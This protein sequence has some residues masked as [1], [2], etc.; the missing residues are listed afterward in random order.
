MVSGV[1]S[2]VALAVGSCMTTANIAPIN[3]KPIVRFRYGDPM[4][5]AAR[6]NELVDRINELERK[7]SRPS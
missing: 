4:P 1:L 6:M 7:Q 2:A 3:R 5:G